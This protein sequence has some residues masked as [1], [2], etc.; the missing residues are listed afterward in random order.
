MKNKPVGY[1]ISWPK[2]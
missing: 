1:F 2:L